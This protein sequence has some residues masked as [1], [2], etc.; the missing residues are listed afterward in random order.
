[1]PWAMATTPGVELLRA[2]TAA[3]T[4]VESNAMPMAVGAS[5][6]ASPTRR[7]MPKPV[8][9][10][11]ARKPHMTPTDTPLNKVPKDKGA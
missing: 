3:M 10:T 11:M 9:C 2:A 6:W 8:D 4:A 7:S 5:D 1:M